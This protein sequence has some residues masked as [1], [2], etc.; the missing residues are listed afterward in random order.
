M[1]AHLLS[2]QLFQN[3]QF[4]NLTFSQMAIREISRLDRT[5]PFDIQTYSVD[6]DRSALAGAVWSGFTL[7][8]TETF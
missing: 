8:A 7:L 2:Q 6:P 4:E 3:S 1:Y 5:T